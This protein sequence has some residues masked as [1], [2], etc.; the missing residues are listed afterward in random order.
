[1]GALHTPLEVS[2]SR[3]FARFGGRQ[4]EMATLEAA[5]GRAIAGSAQVVGIVGEPGVGKSRLCFEF[6]ERC[7]ARGLAIFEAHGVPHGRALPLLPMLELFRSFF[8]ITEQDPDLAAREK[9]AGRFL[10]LDEGRR[11]DLPLVFDLLGVS[12]PERPAPPMDPES[13]QRQLAATVKRVTRMWGRRQP[14]VTF[15][16]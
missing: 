11:E 6:L 9:I 13:R 16:E 3:G 12:G 1:M 15:L 7:R 14:S 10:L 8:G 4:D 2:R 5:L